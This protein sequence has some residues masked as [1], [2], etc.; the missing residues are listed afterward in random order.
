MFEAGC[1]NAKNNSIRQDWI[2]SKIYSGIKTVP[3]IKARAVRYTVT[4][5]ATH[6]PSLS[7]TLALTGNIPDGFANNKFPAVSPIRSSATLPL[8]RHATPKHMAPVNGIT[9]CICPMD[10]IRADR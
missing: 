3:S 1:S 9:R 5:F 2:A 4:D 8:I 7:A 10:V 6:C